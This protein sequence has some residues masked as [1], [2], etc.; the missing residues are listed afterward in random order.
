M[1]P[2][3]FPAMRGPVEWASKKGPAMTT[4]RPREDVSSLQSREIPAPAG[5]AVHLPALFPKF[6]MPSTFSS[7]L[8]RI[9]SKASF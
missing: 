2:L 9:T 4:S 3:T 6:R 5:D 7:I 8:L 1:A